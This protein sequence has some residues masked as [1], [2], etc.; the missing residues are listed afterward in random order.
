MAFKTGN[1]SFLLFLRDRLN[2]SME[3]IL[4]TMETK[5]QK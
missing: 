3:I 1:S 4:E 2:I 5:K